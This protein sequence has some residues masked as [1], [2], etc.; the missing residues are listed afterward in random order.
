MEKLL[1]RAMSSFP[2][3]F[4]KGL[5][6]RGVKGVTAWEWVNHTIPSFNLF[7]SDKLLDWSKLEAFTD[8]NMN[9]T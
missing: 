6:P 1:V 3:V 9:E 7:P 8:D 4:S 2:T 5:F